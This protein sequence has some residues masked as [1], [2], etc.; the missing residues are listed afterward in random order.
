M[1]ASTLRYLLAHAIGMR[2]VLEEEER[3]KEE[4][5]GGTEEGGPLL[6]F[7][8][9]QEDE[10]EKE[11]ATTSSWGTNTA[12][13]ARAPLLLF[14]VWCVLGIM[15]GVCQKDS[16]ALL[17]YSGSGLCKVG[18]TGDYA[19]R[20]VFPSV[21]DRPEML[22]IMAVLNKKNS[23]VVIGCRFGWFCW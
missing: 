2:K 4:E 19:P 15:A 12:M 1:D 18:F 22:G 8:G 11:E 6:S 10:E 21:D 20:S 14:V 3:R 5:G 7:L 17:V 13:W 16:G 23:Y 9:A